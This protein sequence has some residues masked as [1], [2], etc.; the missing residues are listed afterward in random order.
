MPFEQL[1][2]FGDLY[3]PEVIEHEIIDEKENNFKENSIEARKYLLYNIQE[4]KV[5]EENSPVFMD[6]FQEGAKTFHPEI[7]ANKEYILNSTLLGSNVI[8]ESE[9]IIVKIKKNKTKAEKGNTVQTVADVKQPYPLLSKKTKKP[10]NPVS[11]DLPNFPDA[12]TLQQKMYYSIGEVA[13]WFGVNTSMIR[14]WENEFD[15]VQPRKTKKGDRLFRLEDIKNLRL[16][17]HLLKTKKF[18][19]EGAKDYLKTNKKNTD[20]QFELLNSLTKLKVFLLEMKDRV[21]TV[22]KAESL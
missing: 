9:Q 16:I 13:N 1:D 12:D 17:Y 22:S 11:L 15:I 4:N 14:Y 6:T 21:N 7:H 8:F 10:N 5:Q 3:P 20:I 2:L 18:S 19:I